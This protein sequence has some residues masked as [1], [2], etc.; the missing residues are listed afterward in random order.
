[1]PELP[2]VETV[3]KTLKL[4]LIGKK[5]LSCNIFH[6][7]IIEYHNP[8]EFKQKIINQSLSHNFS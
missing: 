5:I 6:D 3:R 4:K 1:M 2:E 8:I 7:N